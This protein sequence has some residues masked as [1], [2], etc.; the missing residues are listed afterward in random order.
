[1]NK[2]YAFVFSKTMPCVNYA[3]FTRIMR[4]GFRRVA[5]RLTRLD[6]VFS[7]ARA[8][9][10][11]TFLFFPMRRLFLALPAIL[12]SPKRAMR[13]LCSLCSHNAQ[14]LETC[15]QP[16]NAVGR[17]LFPFTPVFVF[18][19]YVHPRQADDG[20]SKSVG[21]VRAKRELKHRHRLCKKNGLLEI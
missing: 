5:N 20:N 9:F 12:L 19:L 15:R 21:R 13:Q 11:F 16:L 3:R 4:G 7:L 6:A 10:V 14:P 2:N 1:M 8:V 18:L 17:V